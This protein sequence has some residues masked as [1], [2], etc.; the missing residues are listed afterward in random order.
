MA[1]PIQTSVPAWFVL[2]SKTYIEK[3][4]GDDDSKLEMPR[5]N[6]AARGNYVSRIIS[7]HGIIARPTGTI[8]KAWRQQIYQRSGHFLALTNY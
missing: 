5:G 3:P 8:I 4:H 7:L 1:M 2:N 6:V